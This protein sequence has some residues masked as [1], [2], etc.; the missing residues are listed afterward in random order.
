[1][2]STWVSVL[3]I[4]IIYTLLSIVTVGTHTYGNTGDVAPLAVLMNKMLGLNA[5]V[6][7]AIV[8]CI[9]CLGTLNVF[10][11]SSSRLGYYPV[12]SMQCV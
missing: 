8:S 2:R 7:T 1:M 5:G 11:A 3:L 4:G 10:L 12:R 9:V 6:A